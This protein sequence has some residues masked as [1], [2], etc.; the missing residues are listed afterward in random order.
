MK[1]GSAMVQI[2]IPHWA[3]RMW[4]SNAPGWIILE[5]EIGKGFTLGDLLND[6]VTRHAYLQKVVF[7]QSTG[8][9]SDQIMVILNDS[10]VQDRDVAKCELK[11][12]DSVTLL[13]LYA[14]G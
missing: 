6:L 3:A 8:A 7:D 1:S 4:G 12:G 13:P 14:G 10:L 11:E 5:K 9:V 2:K